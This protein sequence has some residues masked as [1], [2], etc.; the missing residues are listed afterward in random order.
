M[1]G[2]EKNKGPIVDAEPGQC[3]GLRLFDEPLCEE[4][5]EQQLDADDFH[6]A[7]RATSQVDEILFVAGEEPVCTGGDDTAENGVIFFRELHIEVK[8]RERHPFR[9]TGKLLP[10]RR[11]VQDDL[12]FWYAIGQA[13]KLELP[14]MRPAV[15]NRRSLMPPS[16]VEVGIRHENRV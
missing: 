14:P 4:V 2:R 6:A 10:R 16:R 11:C 5:G 12:I 13:C 1:Q 7:N 8:K 9:G 3:R 15:S